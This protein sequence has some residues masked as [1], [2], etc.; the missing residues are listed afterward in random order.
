MK[1]KEFTEK[2]LKLLMEMDERGGVTSKSQRT[3]TPFA[4]Y[5][6]IGFLK[7]NGLVFENGTDKNNRKV[8]RLTEKGKK[9]VKHLKA[10]EEVL[11]G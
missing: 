11:N 5:L 10:I 1:L 4:F 2:N 3:Y 8:W 7:N 6:N 9:F